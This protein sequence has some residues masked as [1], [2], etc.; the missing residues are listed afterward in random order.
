MADKVAVAMRQAAALE[1]VRQA[2]IRLGARFALPSVDLAPAGRD[3]ALVRALQLEA[4]A[5]LLEELVTVT[6]PEVTAPNSAL[7][8]V[9]RAPVAEQSTVARRSKGR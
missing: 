3:P 9:E 5:T 4:V 1:R 8:D 7:Q 2:V 6:A